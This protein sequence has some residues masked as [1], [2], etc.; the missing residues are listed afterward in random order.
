VESSH[1]AE[2]VGR[3]L[4]ISVESNAEFSDRKLSLPPEST[5]L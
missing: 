5:T 3:E 1:Y 4:G 2:E